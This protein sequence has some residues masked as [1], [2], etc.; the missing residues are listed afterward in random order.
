MKKYAI[1]DMIAETDEK[2]MKLT[3]LLKKTPIQHTELLW[4]KALRSS[5]VDED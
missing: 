2:I 5:Q 3:Q 1:D 4:A